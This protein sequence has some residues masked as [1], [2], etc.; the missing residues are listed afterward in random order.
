MRIMGLDPGT[1]NIGVAVSDETGTIAQARQTLRRK[2]DKEAVKAVLEMA[3][4]MNV[5]LIVVG[6]PLNMDGSEGERARYSRGLAGM[7]ESY[8]D[9]PVELWDE[10]LSTVEA[11]KVMLEADISR[12][13]RKRAIDS[14]AARFILQGYLDHARLREKD[15]L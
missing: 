6:L 7:L 13:K 5:S 1:K 9:I 3:R 11:E 14:L 12:K 15:G 10:R 2:N 8:G 4:G